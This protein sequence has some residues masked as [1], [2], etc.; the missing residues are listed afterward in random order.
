VGFVGVGFGAG[1]A[2]A[3]GVGLGLGTGVGVGVGVATMTSGDGTDAGE[4]AAVELAAAMSAE[5]A[6]AE[7]AGAALGAGALVL[8]AGE[9]TADVAPADGGWLLVHA[10]SAAAQTTATT[11][12]A[13]V[14]L[15]VRSRLA[16]DARLTRPRPRPFRHPR[17]PTG[18]TPAE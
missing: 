10:A 14:G 11:Q 12:R 5:V 17:P 13:G 3:V 6:G 1:V 2:A 15:V 18:P 8:T 4:L 7:L 9:P 16:I